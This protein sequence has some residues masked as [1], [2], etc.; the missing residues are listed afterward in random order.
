[1]TFTLGLSSFS[2]PHV[3][4]PVKLRHVVIEQHEMDMVLSRVER[5]E[6]LDWVGKRMDIDAIRLQ[7]LLNGFQEFLRRRRWPERRCGDRRR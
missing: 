3:L 1:M 2:H 5:V 6:S 7:Q 4:A